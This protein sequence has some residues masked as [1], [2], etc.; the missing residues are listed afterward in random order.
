MATDLIAIIK[1]KQA[2]IAKLQKELDAA[3]AL[4]SGAIG[5]LPGAPALEVRSPKR[6]AKHRSSR[7]HGLPYKPGSSVGKAAKV[8]KQAGKPLHVDALVSMMKGKVSKATLVGN[9]SRYV[10]DGKVF[11]RVAP[12]TFGLIEWEKGTPGAELQPKP[13]PVREAAAA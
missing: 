8:L 10:N 7:T 11:V 13:A 4:L 1:D 3:K 5:E 6:R 12:G 2:M 9:L